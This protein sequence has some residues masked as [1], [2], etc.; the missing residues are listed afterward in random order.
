VYLGRA[1]IQDGRSETTFPIVD[2]QKQWILTIRRGSS[3]TIETPAGRFPCV[4]AQ[5]A[6][7]MPPGEPRGQNSKFEGLFGIQGTIKI[8]MDAATGIPVLISG[9]LPVPVIQSLDLNVKLRSYKGT[10][11]SFAPAR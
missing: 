6:T 3:R 5:L 11:K 8:W 4:L 10:P 9:E 1:M 2:K 7:S